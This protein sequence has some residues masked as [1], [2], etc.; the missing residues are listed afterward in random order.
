MKFKR[1]IAI[2]LTAL[3]IFCSVPF[4]ALAAETGVKPVGFK[5]TQYGAYATGEM[6]L[7]ERYVDIDKFK[8]HLSK[9]LINSEASIDFNQYKIPYNENA[10]KAVVYLICD[11]IPEFFHLDT[12]K[13][14]WIYPDS[15][16]K[17][18]TRMT[19]SY[20]YSKT[21]FKTMYDKVMKKVDEMI[22]DLKDN[23]NL[24][25]VQKAL[26]LHDRIALE[27]QYDEGYYTGGK[28]GIHYDSYTMYGV[29]GKGVGVCQGYAET[30]MYLLDKVGIES[31][32][33]VSNDLWHAWNIVYIGGKPYYVDITWDD[34]L[35]NNLHKDIEGQVLHNNFLI[36]YSALY[37]GVNGSQGHKAMDYT[38]ISSDGKYDNYFWQKSNTA[39]Q[40]VGD[41]LYYI[42]N[43]TAELKRYSNQSTVYNVADTWYYEGTSYWPG[44]FTKLAG[45]RTNMFFNK[46]KKLYRYSPYDNT[47][48][49][50]AMTNS[51]YNYESICGLAYKDGK[52]ILELSNDPYYSR[53]YP[54]EVSKDYDIAPPQVK[55]FSTYSANTT[56]TVTAT[57]LDD[58]GIAGYWWGSNEDYTKNTYTANTATSLV[59]KAKRSGNYYLTVK[60]VYGNISL[61]YYFTYNKIILNANGG[62]VTPS[63]I[64]SVKNCKITFPTPTRAGYTF[65]GWSKSKTATSGVKTLTPTVDTTYYAIWARNSKP[66]LYKVDGVWYYYV[67]G[68]INKSNTLVKHTD[69]KWYHVK[70]GKVVKDTTLVK[71]NGEWLYVKNGVLNKSNTLVKY[72]GK[73]FHVKNGKLV[74][75]TTLVKYNGKWYYIKNGVMNKSNT[76]VKYGG[77]WYHVNKGVRTNYTGLVKY[78]GTWYYVKNGIKNTA[79]TL[80]KYNGKWYHVKNGKTVKDTTLVSYGG[81]W[82]YVKNGV[83]NNSNTLVKYGNY[84]YHV[85]NGKLTNETTFVKYGNKWYYVMNGVKATGSGWVYRTGKYYYVKNGVVSM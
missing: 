61:T 80:V 57:F 59:F 23:K 8:A 21:Q 35:S 27:C 5:V 58:S 31:E 39:F 62:T 50:V 60:D 43:S 52:L 9:Q 83:V 16:G 20:K 75:D 76:L 63:Y 53:S 85:R 84:W 29:L 41:E 15:A 82:Y 33:C 34:P 14:V 68:K 55:S 26:L 78:N 6:K 32:V 17:Y 2:I 71:Y 47:V 28:E 49:E 81:K 19:V 74:K 54:R 64:I 25:H 24:S 42:D 69:G 1:I 72:D 18:I 22:F 66:G 38:V 30:Y 3:T 46:A 77:K 40:L 70:G 56:Q 13:D 12:S 79:N 73:W 36:S 37:N 48:Y 7:L 10:R 4:T 44:N 11:E 45:D 67:N 51:L 65:K